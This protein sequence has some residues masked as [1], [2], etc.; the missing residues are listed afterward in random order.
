MIS[1]IENRKLATSRIW[2]VYVRA[3]QTIAEAGDSVERWHSNDESEEIIDESVEGLINKCFPRHVGNTLQLVVDEK[4]WSHHYK[5]YVTQ[6]IL[7]LKLLCSNGAGGA[8]SWRTESVDAPSQWA[9]NPRI[10]AL[11]A[12]I[13]ERVDSIANNECIKHIWEV[14][15]G[16][17]ILEVWFMNVLSKSEGS[18]WS[19]TCSLVLAE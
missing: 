7:S 6:K 9:K 3:T 2:L 18:H 8:G 13:D 14:V 15:H 19:H 4:L 12:L 1:V 16:N 10:P 5:T 11:V 17:V